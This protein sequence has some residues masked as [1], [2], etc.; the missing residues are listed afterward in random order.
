MGN[1]ITDS[2]LYNHIL[3]DLTMIYGAS[4]PTSWAMDAVISSL[5][6]ILW[7][8]N[9][10]LIPSSLFTSTFDSPAS[11]WYKAVHLFLPFAGSRETEI[12]STVVGTSSY[13]VVL[14]LAVLESSG[15]YDRFVIIPSSL[16]FFWKKTLS[17]TIACLFQQ[18]T[19]LFSWHAALPVMFFPS[20]LC[21]WIFGETLY[22]F[23]K[24][25]ICNVCVS[26]KDARKYFAVS[27]CCL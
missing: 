11:S 24:K 27:M 17:F 1:N 7:M 26:R 5:A 9:L 8:E 23:Q 22:K 15:I 2:L 25:K 14:S 13:T 12:R 16:S 18:F 6:L 19:F 20:S 3:S 21:S 4:T 10:A